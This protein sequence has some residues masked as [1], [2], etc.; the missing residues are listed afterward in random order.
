VLIR[1]IAPQ[2]YVSQVGK[3]AF[4]ERPPSPSG[5]IQ[6]RGQSAT[7]SQGILRGFSGSPRSSKKQNFGNLKPR[8]AGWLTRR[9]SRSLHS[10]GQAKAC[11]LA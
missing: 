2:F 9:S 5:H 6:K 7:S 11:P 8:T 4:T 1:C 3:N 10:L